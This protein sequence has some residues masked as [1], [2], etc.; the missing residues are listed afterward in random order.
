M[1]ERTDLMLLS[2]NVHK[3]I[4]LRVVHHCVVD[5]GQYI[6]SD[7]AENLWVVGEYFIQL[8]K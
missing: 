3:K 7:N 4:Y 5:D 6:R 1:A 2:V 8:K